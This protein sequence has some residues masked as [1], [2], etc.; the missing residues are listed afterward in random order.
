MKA[1]IRRILP[2]FIISILFFL[3]TCAMAGNITTPEWY[4][5]NAVF[6]NPPQIGLP[7]VV[8]VTLSAVCGDLVDVKL[9]LIVPSGCVP[10][11][12]SAVL[13]TIR[14]GSDHT[15]T[16]S[17][18]P[19]NPLPNGSIGCSFTAKIP[20]AALE[21]KIRRTVKK[22]EA[23]EMIRS[24]KQWPNVGGGFTDI[25]FALFKE[26][27]FYPLGADMWIYYDDRLKP[28]EMPKGPVLYRE[29]LIT[30]FQ[31]Q[32][33]VEMYDK[34]RV[35]LRSNAKLA[36]DIRNA[37]IDLEKKRQ[38]FVLGLYVM[39]TEAYLKNDFTVAL[40]LLDRIDAEHQTDP[41]GFHKETLAAV[42]NLSALAHW[43][44]GEKKLAEKK[45]RNTFYSDRKSRVQRYILRNL[46]LLS[47]DLGE[48]AGAKEIFRLALELKPAYSLLNDEYKIVKKF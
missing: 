36:E 42:G 37:G 20:K 7:S 46:G 34:L 41:K 16:F 13:E 10:A 30:S 14:A 9:S 24:V 1:Q 23:E 39:A 33:D 35:H 48:K 47:L 27:G 6:E 26:E 44:K 43:G 31:A 28:A 2:I 29:S 5:F 19:K 11:S 3:G 38:D 21:E 18:T 4:R 40:S 45:L 22:E 25:S 17:I 15:F 32:E 12:P 8:K